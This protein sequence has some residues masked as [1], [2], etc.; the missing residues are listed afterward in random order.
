MRISQFIGV[1][2]LLRYFS[3][4]FVVSLHWFIL[5]ESEIR[6]N[7]QALIRAYALHFTVESFERWRNKI[8][9]LD[10][11][12]RLIGNIIHLLPL[13]TVPQQVVIVLKLLHIRTI[14]LINV[15]RET[16]CAEQ[17]SVCFQAHVLLVGE[18]M[19]ALEMPSEYWVGL[20]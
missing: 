1:I 8:I 3:E 19:A 12:V 2:I 4:D 6:E 9:L 14:A 13:L 15:L 16:A 20:P 7:I 5:K 11:E 10:E 18:G 17:S